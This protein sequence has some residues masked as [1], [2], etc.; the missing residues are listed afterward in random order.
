[1]SHLPHC[2]GKLFNIFVPAPNTID[3]QRTL[4]LR[5]EGLETGPW[6]VLGRLYKASLNRI[7]VYVINLLPNHPATP[8]RNCSET[9]LPN[10]MALSADIKTEPSRSFDDALR[11]E[12]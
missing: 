4:A 2:I 7:R 12:T 1:M 8:Q 9:L 5:I 10:V 6:I 11:R 3:S